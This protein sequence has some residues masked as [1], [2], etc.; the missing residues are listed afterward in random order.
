MKPLISL[1][2][3]TTCRQGGL[4]LGKDDVLVEEDLFDASRRH[5]V[6]IVRRMDNLLKSHG[7]NPGDVD[8]LYVSAGPGSFTGTRVGIT[9]ARTMAQVS[10]SL[11]VV[12]VSTAQAIARNAEDLDWRHLGVVMSSKDNQVYAA[13]FERRDDEAVLTCPGEMVDAADFLARSP[14][15]ILLIGEALDHVELSGEG[16]SYAPRDLFL[17]R[18][19]GVWYIGRRES[20]AGHFT[21][22]RQ[23]LPIYPRKP[24]AQRLWENKQ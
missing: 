22:D 18:P 12:A 21:D 15:P 16:V 9:V 6:R 23:L 5:A 10:H 20:S 24:E 19:G 2:I 7:L 17:P 13:L 11:K 1:A 3:E 8:E 4:A 14:R